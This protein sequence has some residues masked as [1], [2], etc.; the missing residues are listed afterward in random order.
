MD[1]PQT[2]F[3]ILLQQDETN[4]PLAPNIGH[5]ARKDKPA[6]GCGDVFFCDA[7]L[8]TRGSHGHPHTPDLQPDALPG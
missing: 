8:N 3:G 2:V 6:F 4:P 1:R 7:S 5:A